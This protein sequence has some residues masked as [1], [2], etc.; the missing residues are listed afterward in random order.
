MRR[1]LRDDGRMNST[2]WPPASC[3]AGSEMITCLSPK[4][5][6]GW[7]TDMRRLLLVAILAS[8][9]LGRFAAA[10]DRFPG[11]AWDHV[12]PA[13]A[14]WSEASLADVQDWSKQIHS[15]AFM[16]IHRGAVVA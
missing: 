2:S 13:Q 12:P 3:Q 15:T 16:V 4:L 10:Q 5:A 11:V 7:R 9:L 14:G 8:L 1:A 6:R